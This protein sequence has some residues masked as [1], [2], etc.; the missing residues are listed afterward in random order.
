MQKRLDR[1]P[2][3]KDLSFQSRFRLNF[4]LEGRATI[5]RLAVDVKHTRRPGEVSS[6]GV[7][8]NPGDFTDNPAATLKIPTL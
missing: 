1:Q 7:W 2:F 5:G 8:I 4:R 6:T 3:G